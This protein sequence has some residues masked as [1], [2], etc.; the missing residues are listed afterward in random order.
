GY[1]GEGETI[2]ECVGPYTW[3]PYPRNNRGQHRWAEEH[4]MRG[5]GA[6]G[7]LY[8]YRYRGRAY[9]EGGG[10]VPWLGLVSKGL[11]SPE[12]PAWGGWSGRFTAD[13]QKNIY[14]RHESVRTDEQGYGDFYAYAEAADTWTDPVDGTTYDDV[15]APIW[16]WRRAMANNCRARFDWCVASF[17]EANHHPRAAV[18][19]D[20]T[21]GFVRVAASP[22]E[23]L[24]FDASGSTDP[25]GDR[26]TYR[27]YPYPEA[28][29]L[30]GVAIAESTAATFEVVTPMKAAGRQLHVILEATDDG[31]PPL[32]DYRRVVIDVNGS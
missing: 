19:G 20:A 5:H 13:K 22:G 24:T 7:E 32:V 6:L 12:H 26:L 31:T 25:D 16:R 29:T 15:F 11:S 17:D 18:D 3:R 21:D 2:R 1:M 10:T 4:I 28:G 8:P 14:S 27:W 23:K 9:L 30:A